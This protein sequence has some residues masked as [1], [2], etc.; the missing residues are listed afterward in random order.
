MN[1]QFVTIHDHLFEQIIELLT[2]LVRLPSILYYGND[3][4]LQRDR[5]FMLESTNFSRGWIQWKGDGVGRLLFEY[6]L[7]K[8]YKCEF[9]GIHGP[10]SRCILSVGIPKDSFY[11]R[12]LLMS[13][14][15]FVL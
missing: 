8:Y 14:S 15:G 12:F 5:A 13:G 10:L 7:C 3:I 1:N 6:L 2:A 9:S 4:V 11:L